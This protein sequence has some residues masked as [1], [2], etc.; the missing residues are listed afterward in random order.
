MEKLEVV[1]TKKIMDRRVPYE[2]GLG[3]LGPYIIVVS[4]IED[5][6]GKENMGLTKLERYS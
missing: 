2:I 6:G 1:V 4:K 5:L 3:L